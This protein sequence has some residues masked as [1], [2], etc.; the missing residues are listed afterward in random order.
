MFLT[1]LD[2]KRSESGIVSTLFITECSVASQVFG[3]KVNQ[4]LILNE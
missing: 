2:N 3:R 1:P 4:Q